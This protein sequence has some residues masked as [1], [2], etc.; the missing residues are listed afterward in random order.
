MPREDLGSLDMDLGMHIRNEFGLWEG[1]DG[2]VKDCAAQPGAEQKWLGDPDSSWKL[3]ADH[4]RR[5]IRIAL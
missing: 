4:L 2:L 1:N 5:Q 3:I